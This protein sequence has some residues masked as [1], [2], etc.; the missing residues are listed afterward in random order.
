M[1]TAEEAIKTACR[2]HGRVFGPQVAQEYGINVGT[3]SSTLFRMFREGTLDRRLVFVSGYRQP[4]LYQYW[5][6]EDS[7]GTE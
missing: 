7:E 6:T 4:A 3:V 5:L 1:N 2:V